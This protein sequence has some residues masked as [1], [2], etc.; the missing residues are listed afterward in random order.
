M[1]TFYKLAE[2]SHNYIVSNGKFFI[3]QMTIRIRVLKDI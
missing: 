2:Y 1:Y 3:I